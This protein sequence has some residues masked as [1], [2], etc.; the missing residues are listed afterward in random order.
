MAMK[1]FNKEKKAKPTLNIS[2]L[3]E[4]GAEI[5]VGGVSELPLKEDYVIARSIEL[6]ND[7]APCVIHR[8]CIAKM[9]Q[10]DMFEK[11]AALKADGKANNGRLPVADVAE[12]L[13]HVDLNTDNGYIAF[14]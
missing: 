11:I 1:L 3:A 13:E 10:I 7:K 9:F 14:E 4:N 8:T 12:L 6:Y 2:V 5:Y